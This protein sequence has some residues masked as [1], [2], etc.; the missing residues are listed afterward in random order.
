MDDWIG[1]GDFEAD[2][3]I[4][5]DSHETMRDSIDHSN[6][7]F[8]NDVKEWLLWLKK[9]VGFDVWSTTCTVKSSFFAIFLTFLFND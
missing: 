6:P 4:P 1:E 9:D 2:D 5:Q 7:V 8:Q 3:E